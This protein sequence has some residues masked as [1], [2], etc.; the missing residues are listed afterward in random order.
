MAGKANQEYLA[1]LAQVAH[2]MSQSFKEQTESR[3]RCQSDLV[4]K[5]GD[6]LANKSVP[7]SNIASSPPPNQSINGMTSS[8]PS[9]SFQSP[10][11]SH[12]LVTPPNLLNPA[13]TSGFSAH[14][15]PL[16]HFIG[17][18]SSGVTARDPAIPLLYLYI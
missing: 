5:L 6:K 11:S 9:T 3:L 18:T 13:A 8:M 15:H 1:Q 17:D 16:G 4:E 14:S 10:D 2:D 12:P 7:V